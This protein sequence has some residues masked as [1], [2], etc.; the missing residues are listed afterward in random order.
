MKTAAKKKPMRRVVKARWARVRAPNCHGSCCK[1]A[2]RK[3]KLDCGH[4]VVR[5]AAW[6]GVQDPWK[7]PHPK[8]VRCEE[9]P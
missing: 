5:H 9:C 3:L 1:I 2:A 4:T 7:I 6:G 8:R